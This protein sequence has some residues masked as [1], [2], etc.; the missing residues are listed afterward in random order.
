[1]NG[2]MPFSRGYRLASARPP[3]SK[4]GSVQATSDRPDTPT[5]LESKYRAKALRVA[6]AVALPDADSIFRGG[7]PW[8][9]DGM[10]Y[11]LSMGSQREGGRTDRI[12]E[13]FKGAGS[14]AFRQNQPHCGDDRHHR[15]GR[16]KRHGV[17]RGL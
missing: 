8:L 9:E 16:A 12:P 6:E 2:Q 4:G 10:T 11:H 17:N 7:W 15:S 3:T 14:N 13:V 1:V 5:M